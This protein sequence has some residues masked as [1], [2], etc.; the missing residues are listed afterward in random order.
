M[1]SGGTGVWGLGRETP[2]EIYRAREKQDFL[3]R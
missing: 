3:G 1:S 2:Q